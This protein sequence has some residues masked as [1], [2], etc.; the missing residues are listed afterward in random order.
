VQNG[1]RERG[2]IKEG[3]GT[4][5]LSLSRKKEEEEEEREKEKK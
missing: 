1:R 4:R 5:D 3:G 2:R